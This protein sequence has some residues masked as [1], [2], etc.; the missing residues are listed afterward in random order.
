MQAFWVI[1]P[2]RNQ[3]LIQLEKAVLNR[4]F[5]SAEEAQETLSSLTDVWHRT[6]YNLPDDFDAKDYE[7][8]ALVADWPPS[9]F[10]WP[11]VPLEELAGTPFSPEDVQEVEQEA[12][13]EP[14]WVVDLK[15]ISSVVA[16]WPMKT[17][18]EVGLAVLGT[19]LTAWELDETLLLELGGKCK[20]RITP[21][22][23]MVLVKLGLA[24]EADN[25]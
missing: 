3:Q 7:V 19:A 10:S 20:L 4:F 9:Q 21:S 8:V 14:E 2:R 17:M 1:Q 5:L 24:P 15:E 12:E 6:Y 13:A 11:T 18:Q 22:K 25:V 16:D 23:P